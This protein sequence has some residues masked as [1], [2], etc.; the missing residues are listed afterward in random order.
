MVALAAMT[1]E[2]VTASII[3]TIQSIRDLPGLKYIFVAI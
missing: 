3:V 1:K 2:I